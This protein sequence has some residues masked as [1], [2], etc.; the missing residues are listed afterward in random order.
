MT[1]RQ[2]HRR[3]PTGEPLQGEADAIDASA[4]LDRTLLD[5]RGARERVRAYLGALGLGPAAAERTG[6]RVLERAL[7]RGSRPSAIADAMDE[8]PRVLREDHPLA[9]VGP[10]ADAE[11]GFLAWRLAAWSAGRL[12]EAEPLEARPLEPTPPLQRTSMAS[13]RFLGRRL[14]E[15]RRRHGAPAAGRGTDPGREERQRMRASWS[16]RGHRRRLLLTL[17]VLAPSVG[18]GFAFL[19]TL[20][21]RVW[22]PAEVALAVFFGALFGWISLGFWTAVFGFVLLRRGGDPLAIQRSVELPAAPDGVAFRTALVMPICDEPVAPVFARLRAMHA[23]LER[24]GAAEAFDFFVLSDSANPDNWVEEEA[25]WAAWRRAAGKGGG[26]FYRRRR[27]RQK[28]KSGNV[29][30]FCRRFGRGYRY[31]VVL[32]ADSLMSGASLVRLVQL[33]EANPRV[34][35]I[36][37][38]PQVVRARSLFGRIQ[39]FA[40]RLYGPMFAAGMH[41]WQLGDSPYWGH[42]AILRVEPFMRHAAL[43][44]LSGRPPFGGDI[45]SHDFVEAAL[46]GRAGWSIWLAFDLPGSY[47]EA[48]GS[49]LEE[50]Q[51][52]QRWC[53][54][55]LQH[56]RLLFTEG[57]ASAHRVLFL[58]G[59][60]AYVSAVLWLGFLGAGTAE[61]L[62]WAI[63]GPNYFPAEQTLFP[64]WPVWR[65]ERIGALFAAVFAVLLLPKLLAVVLAVRKGEAAGFGGA[66]ALVRS[67]LL[68]TLA[69][70]L[71]APIRL[72]FYCRV[73]ILNLLGRAVGWRGGADDVG[74]T[75]W[76]QALRRHGADTLVA[77]AWALG[78]HWLHPA[79]FWWLAPV[80]GALVLSGPLSVLASRPALGARA[81]RVG[82]L[83][84]PEE[85]SPPPEI[86]DLEARLATAAP[87]R[88][89]G[90]VRAVV[91]PALNA[92]HT[93]LLRGPRSWTPRIAAARD[94]LAERVLRSGPAA[95]SDAEKRVVLSDAARLLE[96]H[97]R[98]WRLEDRETS[99]RWGLVEVERRGDQPEAG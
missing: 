58:N 57:L 85:Q 71:F 10:E 72:A 33:M 39:Q 28:R 94:A 13:E 45:L 2:R 7:V 37:T 67:V 41:Y 60:F 87:S 1:G 70:A 4:L 9:G 95:L 18:A 17:L 32:D 19:A 23:S 42:N 54:G 84:T 30:D 79:A 40:S 75:S 24:T 80:A 51:R 99:W 43:P 50:M 34:G 48:P 3:D 15:W 98:V 91:D 73:V 6:R 68:E 96:L 16:R 53:Q 49:L 64:T 61:A 59:I 44:H 5:W 93:L 29:A 76:G 25:A 86:R 20:P 69:T 62:V 63:R 82:L 77:C 92:V 78:L 35:I 47:E 52:D 89:T 12:E 21:G 81:R 11:A 8:L 14:G 88:W 65:P 36:Q 90:F 74:E 46:L 22:L 27:V 66:G 38:A 26:I 97:G 56:L 83:R 31:M 55:N